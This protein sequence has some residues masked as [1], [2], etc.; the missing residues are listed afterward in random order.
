M[1]DALTHE[2]FGKEHT[3]GARELPW[4]YA[5][6][7]AVAD[8]NHDGLPDLAFLHAEYPTRT[9]SSEHLEREAP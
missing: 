6:G 2:D 1:G 8:F 9:S 4:L 5:E 7:G 3:G